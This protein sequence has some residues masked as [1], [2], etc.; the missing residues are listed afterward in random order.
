[1]ARLRTSIDEAN[2][3]A[4]TGADVIEEGGKKGVRLGPRFRLDG[5]SLQVEALAYKMKSPTPRGPAKR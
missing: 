2:V 5:F 4:V 3:P 1:M